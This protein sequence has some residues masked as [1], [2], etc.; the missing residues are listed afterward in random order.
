MKNKMKY[1][2]IK[3]KLTQEEVAKELGISVS[4]Y[5]MMENGSRNISLQRAKKLEK[6]FNA[7]IDKIFFEE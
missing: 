5:N 2:R 3:N 7:S 6:P 4:A 1:F